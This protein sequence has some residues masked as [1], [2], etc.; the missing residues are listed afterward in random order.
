MGTHTA[1]ALSMSGNAAAKIKKSVALIN[2][3]QAQ[4]RTG[5]TSSP[6]GKTML[7]Q[8]KSLAKIRSS[9]Y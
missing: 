7:M 1:A 9:N 2:P 5:P 6:D 3:Q 4:A 8:Q